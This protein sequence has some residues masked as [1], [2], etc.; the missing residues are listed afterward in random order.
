MLS[1]KILF[2]VGLFIVSLELNVYGAIVNLR[3]LGQAQGVSLSDFIGK[4]LK[5]KEMDS[6][7]VH[8]RKGLRLPRHSLRQT[9]YWQFKIYGK[10]KRE[11]VNYEA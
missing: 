8:R 11:R 10:L 5:F 1:S 9:S 3:R 7:L 6:F 2:S 4:I